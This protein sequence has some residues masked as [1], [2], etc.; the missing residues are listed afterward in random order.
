[1]ISAQVERMMAVG[2]G[3]DGLGFVVVGK[4]AQ[5]TAFGSGGIWKDVGTDGAAG[6]PDEQMKSRNS[7]LGVPLR[8][9]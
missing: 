9:D 2:Y 1:M 8:F 6:E 7:L 5:C 4:I 3:A